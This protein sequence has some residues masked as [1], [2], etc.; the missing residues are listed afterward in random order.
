MKQ[1]A[2]RFVE[3]LDNKYPWSSIEELDEMAG[4][5]YR[6][7]VLFPGEKDFKRIYDIIYPE[8][9]EKFLTENSQYINFTEVKEEGFDLPDKEKIKSVKVTLDNPEDITSGLK[10]ALANLDSSN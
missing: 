2:F 9:L 7:T 3:V 6:S 8:K 1:I 5:Y 10:E 4:V